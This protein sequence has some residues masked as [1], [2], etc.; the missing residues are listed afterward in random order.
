MKRNLNRL[1]SSEYDLLVVGGGIYGVCVARDAILRGL[2]VGLVDKGDFGHATSFNTLRLIHGGFR[3]LQSLDIMRARQSFNEQMVF[4]KI[5]PHLVHPLP[6]LVPTYGHSM[7]GKEV[8]SFA[9]KIYD[10]LVC[11]ASHDEYQPKIPRGRTV[12]RE[13]CLEAF[14]DIERKGLTGGIIFYDC[15]LSDSERL[16]ISLAQSAAKNGAD[17]ANYLE[18]IG[19]IKNKNRIR[20]V[21]VKDTLTGDE[22]DIR[23]SLVVNTS[24]PWLKRILGFINHFSEKHQGLSRAFNLVVKSKFSN[25]FAIGINTRVQNFRTSQLLGKRSRYLFIAP[26]KDDS[27][28]GTEHLPTA[29]DPDNLS[30]SEEEIKNFLRDINEAYP[31]ASL[32]LRDVRFVYKG[33]LPT[34]LTSRGSAKLASKYRIYDHGREN[35]LEGLISVSGVKF[36]EARRVAEKVVDLVSTK[37]NRKGPKSHAAVTPAYGGKIERFNDFILDEIRRNSF[38]LSQIDVQNLIAHY[39]SVYDEV[40]ESLHKRGQLRFANSRVLIKKAKI[41]YAIREEMA[42]RLSDVVFRRTDLGMN[43]QVDNADIMTCAEMMAG[44]L[45]WNR[46]RI[47]KEI[48]EVMSVL[49]S[50]TLNA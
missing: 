19:F 16:I 10:N 30:I 37:L 2:S 5:A 17:L 1:S 9:L 15:Q 44:E 42:Q 20:G 33:C 22:F 50:L 8:L 26:W 43:A 18:V 4:M 47:K 3:Y 24:G 6:V 48:D 39:G 11:R 25:D 31:Q 35:G 41:L 38:G 36:T 23:A 12:S 45:N 32:R 49:S 34:I 29:D 28:I 21:K 14:P 7:Q 27:L 40:L 46:D 13:E